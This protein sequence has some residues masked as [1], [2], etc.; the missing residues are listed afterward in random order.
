MSLCSLS[1]ARSIRPWLFLVVLLVLALAPLTFAM[2]DALWPRLVALLLLAWALPGALLL[3]HWRLPGL[4][5]MS[6]GL[7]AAGLGWCWLL[8]VALLVHWLPGPIGVWPLVAAYALG[9]AALLLALLWR[10]PPLL[11]ALPTM[12]WRHIALLLVAAAA[13]RLPGLGYHEFHFD[14]VLVLTRARE[15]IRGEDDALARHAKGPGEIAATLAVYRTLGTTNETTAR[16]PFALASIGSVLATAAIGRRLFSPAVGLWAGL[17][18]A[19][20]GYALGL[21]RLVQYQPA[22]LLLMA[23]A[24]LAAWEFAQRGLARWLGL[25]AVFSAFGLVMHYEFGLMAPVLVALA[26]LGWRRAPHGATLRAGVAAGVAGSALVAAVYLPLVLNPYFASTQRYL[27]IRAGSPGTFNGSFFVEMGTFY[28]SIYFFVGLLV[29]VVAGLVMGWR[30]ARRPTLLLALWFSPFL[31]VYLFVM[32]FPGTHFYLLMESWSV[33]AALPLAVLTQAT[34]RRAVVRWGT[35]TVV[36]GWLALTVAYLFLMFFRQAPEYLVNFERERVPLYWAPYGA[37][38]PEKP[39]FGFPIFEGWKVLGVLNEWHYLGETYASNE[40][41]RHLRWYLGGF[42][43][44]EFDEQPDF[45]VVATH[46]QEPDPDFNPARLDGYRQVGEVRVRDEPRLALFARQP[47]V[48]PYVTFDAAP[49]LPIFDEVVPPL[50]QWP[51]PPVRLAEVS[52]ADQVTLERA[53]LADSVV[54]SGKTLHLILSWRPEWPLDRDYKVFAHLGEGQPRA[55][56]DGFPGLNTARTS[57]WPVGRRF[58]DHVLL[59]IPPGTPGGSYPLTVGLYDPAS[60]ERL[61]GRA[62]P[63][64]TVT[65]R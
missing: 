50:H 10:R 36:A 63:V 24:F 60:G 15:A 26:W 6:A 27:G 48:V 53:A 13:L 64:A 41:S 30:S 44:V 47:L 18:L 57:R 61:G 23:L 8:L 17:L 1:V 33:V 12:D 16:L 58:E 34:G 65:V 4:D 45:I 54:R 5:V 49:F 39:R 52:L 59:R 22:V 32:R 51:S 7:V 9:A 38:V 31:I 21:S 37:N 20:N 11:A 56:W 19:V 46:L 2:S 55:Q 29:L 25:A 62:V 40:R 14:E 28:N 43:R 35:R 42:E 3:A